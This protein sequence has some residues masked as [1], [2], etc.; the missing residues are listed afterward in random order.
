MD[1]HTANWLNELRILA[2]NPNVNLMG[3]Q[4]KTASQSGYG[5]YLTD[6]GPSIVC[7]RLNVCPML[8]VWSNKSNFY[9]TTMIA[10][11]FCIKQIVTSR[12]IKGEFD[13]RLMFWLFNWE[14]EWLSFLWRLQT[15]RNESL[16]NYLTVNFI[17]AIRGT[18]LIFFLFQLH[19]IERNFAKATIVQLNMPFNYSGWR[20]CF[21]LNICYFELSRPETA[22]NITN[23]FPTTMNQLPKLPKQLEI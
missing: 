14:F 10:L 12:V 8:V 4:P 5:Y 6:K 17:Q 3:C 16:I 1:S 18:M 22:L 23:P 7:V 2:F 15:F 19:T 9:A 11:W 13:E 21:V 20:K